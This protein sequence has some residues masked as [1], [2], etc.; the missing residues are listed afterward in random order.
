MR[1]HDPIDPVELNLVLLVHLVEVEAAGAVIHALVQ[2]SLGLLLALEG[3]VRVS[4]LGV[5][6]AADFACGEGGSLRDSIRSGRIWLPGSRLRA[7]VFRLRL[8]RYLRVNRLWR[9]PEQ[10]VFGGLRILALVL[11]VNRLV[12]VG[13]TCCY[14]GIEVSSSAC[15]LLSSAVWSRLCRL[16]L[17][18]L[19]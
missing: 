5:G 8:Q 16:G 1:H 4:G 3:F 11:R 18:Q 14:L 7:N 17:Y 19:E 9:R 13:A 12:N 10:P 15:P 6:L 2:L